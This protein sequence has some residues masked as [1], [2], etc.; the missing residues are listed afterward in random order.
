VTAS[1]V[2]TY[3]WARQQA[4][5]LLGNMDLCGRIAITGKLTKNRR[6]GPFIATAVD[7]ADNESSLAVFYGLGREAFGLIVLKS[8]GSGNPEGEGITF[9]TSGTIGDIEQQ[10]ANLTRYTVQK[11]GNFELS[12]LGKGFT[13][14]KYG[15]RIINLT[16]ERQLNGRAILTEMGLG[17]EHMDSLAWCDISG[18]TVRVINA[19]EHA[20]GVKLVETAVS[21]LNLNLE[22]LIR[23]PR[24]VDYEAK[25]DALLRKIRFEEFLQAVARLG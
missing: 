23:E 18:G 24:A 17:F 12:L 22:Q 21:Q 14:I 8:D 6:P 25:V 16:Y 11:Q 9:A 19:P 7:K 10:W 3:D 13:R 2:L 5:D 4:L 20:R 1:T 15:E